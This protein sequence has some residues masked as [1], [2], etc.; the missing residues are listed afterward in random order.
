MK[1]LIP[2]NIREIHYKEKVLN[3][4]R[5]FSNKEVELLAPAGNFEIFKNIIN[6]GADAVYFGGKKLNMRMHRKDYN[7]TNDEV[8]DAISLAHSLDKKVYV[9]VN[10]LFSQQDLKDAREFLV[11]LEKAQPDALI[12]QDLSILELINEL[13]LSL[14]LHSS[15]MMNVHNLETIKAIRE[16]GV[17]RIVASR[18]IDLKTIYA[19]H[20]QSDMEF[21]Y[22]THGDMCVAHGAQ[23]LYSA[24]LFGKSSNRG[25]CMKP[26]RWNFTIKKDG[27]IY[28]TEY[29]L[30]VKDMY[31]YEHL[32]EMIEA[33]IVSFKIEGRMRSSDYLVN[34]INFYS[35]AINRY[36]DDPICYD[37]KKDA[38]SIYEGRKRDLSTGYA[39]GKPGLSNINRRY[40]GTGK[41]YSTGK[42]FSKP[43]EEIEISSK[44]IHE[45]KRTLHN[46]VSPTQETILSVKV[47][48]YEQAKLAL[49]EEVDA[50]YLS[51]ETFEPSLPFSKKE[52]LNLTKNK[53]SSKI[54]LSL[55]RMMYEEDFSTY[56]HLLN[57][58]DLGIDGLLVTNLGA[59][60]RFKGLGLELIGDYCLN[61]YNHQ[62]AKFYKNQGLSSA[63]LS[64]E[65]PLL[66]T[67]D[68]ITKSPLPIE[69][70]VH[71][72]PVM[73]YLEHDL[74]ANT[75][76]LSPIGREDNCYVDNSTLVLV[77][78]KG[79]EH[80]VYR[81]NKGRNH[82][83]PYKNLCYL[84]FL[85]ELMA[86]GVKSF[87]IEGSHYGI[88]ALRNILQTYKIALNDLAK[89]NE[90][91]ESLVPTHAGFTL[92]A[93][94]FD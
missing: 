36:I 63:T 79:Y 81:D 25:L 15:V 10:N 70:I 83:I 92:G 80:P 82:L 46:E 77:D 89:C 49:E 16:L 4:S 55:P 8:I 65:A 75:T 76:N 26:C 69:V 37:R 33:G 58:N 19:L 42:V 66:D 9:T 5:F 60:N 74:Y 53:K 1:K 57:Q 2:Q 90:L 39:F 52:I 78:D 35:D 34:L 43:I 72:A 21:E 44:R 3:M 28:P 30:A 17:T 29:P 7:F 87:R 11:F 12:I 48:S 14:N 32:P 27:F 18:D 23:C 38:Q 47:N 71:G 84:P 61:V 67:K 50:I 64:V 6:S 51:G 45:I 68:T 94:Q 40:E 62:S 86:L 88:D 13:G 22:F 93:L 41:F 54:Y 85:K 91:Y 73:M 31:M 59:I 20:K 56:S 24:S